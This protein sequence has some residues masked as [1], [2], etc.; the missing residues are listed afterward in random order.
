MAQSNKLCPM[1]NKKAYPGYI[2]C[3]RTCGKQLQQQC[4]VCIHGII[5]SGYNTCSRSCSLLYNYMSYSPT[6][7]HFFRDNKV[8]FFMTNFWKAYIHLDGETWSS[9]EHYFQWK[10]YDSNPNLSTKL[11]DIIKANIKNAKD[12]DAVFKLTNTRNG[13]YRQYIHN[14]WHN[15]KDDVMQKAVYA[16]FSQN[17]RLRNMLIYTQNI[18]LCEDSPY[19]DYWGIKTQ[20]NGKPGR[21]MLGIMLMQVRDQL[22]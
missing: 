9:V 4:P 14:Y 21:N 2:A 10:K 19:D 3:S 22:Q 15:I 1:C 20:S 7:L 8:G 13:V 6:V 11:K 12:C 18:Q 17:K 5:L 16:K